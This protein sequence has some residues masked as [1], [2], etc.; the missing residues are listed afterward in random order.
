MRKHHNINDLVMHNNYGLGV[1]TKINDNTCI[2]LV[3]WSHCKTIAYDYATI[4]YM[5]ATLKEK[6]NAKT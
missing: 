6:L 4:S 5:K 2:A 1:I 3:H